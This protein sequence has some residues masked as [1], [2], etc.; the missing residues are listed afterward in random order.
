MLLL[1]GGTHQTPLVV[2]SDVLGKWEPGRV[3]VRGENAIPRALTAR[4]PMRQISRPWVKR[5]E[6]VKPIV[7]DG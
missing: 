4:L 1:S 6:N 3:L 7:E 5:I 2:T